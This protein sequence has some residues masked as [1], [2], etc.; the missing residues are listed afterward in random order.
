MDPQNLSDILKYVMCSF[1]G[2]L[3]TAIKL[4]R[5]ELVPKEHSIYHTTRL[6][7]HLAPMRGFLSVIHRVSQ[8][9]TT[10]SIRG[11]IEQFSETILEID[12]MI[13]EAFIDPS[14]ITQQ[15]ITQE[16]PG[17]LMGIRTRIIN[18]LGDL[19]AN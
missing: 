6:R 9:E 7:T 5:E 15:W 13:A 12:E 11:K 19:S 3:K 1:C 14:Q 18:Q 10:G 16:L 2:V 17:R 8:R 4:Q